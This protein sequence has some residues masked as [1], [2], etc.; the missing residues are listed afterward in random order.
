MSNGE[1]TVRT[2]AWGQ[3]LPFVRLFRTFR[4]AIHPVRLMLGLCCIILCCLGG[5]VLDGLWLSREAGV[6]VDPDS[7]Q[8]EIFAYS[9]GSSTEFAGWKKRMERARE[10]LLCGALIKL[11]KADSESQA[12]EL[13]ASQPARELLESEKHRQNVRDARQF[14][15]DH[16]A[17][18]LKAV[19][20]TKEYR[21]KQKKETAKGLRQAADA[22]LILLDG[23]DPSRLGVTDSSTVLFS[24]L[25]SV[26]PAP[27]AQR[28]TE[29]LQTIETQSAI[30]AA[31]RS[32]PRGP[33]CALLDYEMRC[34]AAAIRGALTLHWGF[35]GGVSDAAPSLAGSIVSAARGIAWAITQRPCFS[36]FYAVWH[37][38][39]FA[40]FGGAICRHA[41]VQAAREET[42]PLRQ[43][44]KFAATKY[45][46]LVLAP[47][48]P[49]GI[50]LIGAVVMWLGGL[51]TAIPYVGE[52]LAGVFYGL[53]LLGGFALAMILIGTV[54]GLH[55]M[56]PTIAVE[57]SD[58]FDSVT[59]AV[60]YIGQRGWHAGFYSLLLLLYG[61][62]LFGLVRLIALCTLKL[63]HLVSG[64]AMSIFGAVSSAQTSGLGKL[65]AMWHMP[66]WS[67]LS[68][69]PSAG[70]VPFWGYFFNAPLDSTET[71][72][73]VLIGAWV[74]LVVGLVGAFVVTFFFCGSTQMYVLLRRDVDAVDYDEIYYEEEP[75]GEAVTPAA[76]PAVQAA[77]AAAPEQPAPTAPAP[78]TD[79]P[80]PEEGLGQA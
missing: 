73:A 10:K 25:M 63:G 59:R 35:A 64:A 60:G 23:K 74:L 41:A 79:Q 53:A 18:A 22:L 20:E 45:A 52:I 2:I 76:A 61:S 75:A 65:D 34:F 54:L 56:W 42:I 27:N 70:N 4:L 31:R 80:Q 66:A 58:A 38:V 14:I 6:I 47:A 55:L 50:F 67:E 11:K 62:A 21:G 68:L 48:V 29:V 8:T 26:G 28:R 5:W 12:V 30:N 19:D 69:L 39:V 36:V 46:G 72:A 71:I 7:G 51:L 57:G 15:K 1:G 9:L 78:P 43:A 77:T 3:V 37:F 24:R 17:A 32:D 49:A 33:F 16:L 40:F 44:L 13:L